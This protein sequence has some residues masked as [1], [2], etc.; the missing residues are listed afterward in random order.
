MKKNIQRLV[1]ETVKGRPVPLTG[2]L[3]CPSLLQCQVALHPQKPRGLL[4]T[5]S[6]GRPPRFSHSSCALI[7]SPVINHT[8][9]LCHTRRS[10]LQYPNQRVRYGRTQGFRKKLP[11][12]TLMRFRPRFSNFPRDKMLDTAACLPHLPG[13]TGLE[14]NLPA[15]WPLVKKGCVTSWLTTIAGECGQTSGV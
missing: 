13:A 1:V 14:A 8:A 12:L 4:G 15:S 7:L 3:K 5:G 6:P 11:P 2:K 9:I 10:S